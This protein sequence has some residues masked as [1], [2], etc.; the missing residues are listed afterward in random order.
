[1][2]GFISQ[3]PCQED[4]TGS[5]DGCHDEIVMFLN[6]IT[7]AE[8]HDNG[9]IDSPGGFVVNVIPAGVDLQFCPI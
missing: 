5:D 7:G 6:P 3:G 9:T 2:T 8:T 1:M 4:F